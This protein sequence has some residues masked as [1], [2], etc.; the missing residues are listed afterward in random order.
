MRT[1]TSAGLVLASFAAAAA[2]VF[3]TEPQTV[4]SDA[5]TGQ[6]VTV[7]VDD[8]FWDCPRRQSDEEAL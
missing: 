5:T 7:V 1:R 8:D 2:I 4:G 3:T 6:P